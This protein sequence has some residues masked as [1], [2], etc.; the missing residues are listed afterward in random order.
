MAL[1]FPFRGFRYNK[2]AVGDFQSVVTQP[3]DKTTAS[4]QDAYYQRSSYNVV[5]I[6]LNTEKRNDP[7]T[8]YPE[9]GSTLRQ[10]I[11]Q[12]VLIQDN[13]PAIYAYYQ[14]YAFEGQT[15]L[16]KGFIALLDLKHS[17]SGII[18]H[19][20]TLAAPKQDR[21]RLLRS[22]EG[23]EDL[24]YML[25][26]DDRLE[27]VRILD[28]G[29]SGR[30]P[31][32]E[33]KD[34]FG[35]V[36]RIWA[37]TSPEAITRIQE[38]LGSQ[39]LFIADGHHRFETSVN[40][41]NECEQNGWTTDGVES[42]DK[43]MVACFN[44]AEGVTILATHRLLRDLP[45]FDARAFLKSVAQNFAIE[46]C[47][48]ADDLWEKMKAGRQD[49]VFGFYPEKLGELYLLRLKQPAIEDPILLKH[50]GA[51]RTLDV[52]ILHSLILERCLGIDEG[53]LAAQAHIDYAR[54]R[55]S[56]IRMVDE[57]KY[58]AA[59]FLNPTTA[60]QMQQVASLGERMPQKSTDFYPKLLTGLIF[61]KMHI[62]KG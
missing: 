62:R 20:H 46:R 52:S 57:G 13:L 5:R 22:I 38:A 7:D 2:N 54:E 55:E 47:S 25:Y 41:M 44:S 12:K 26:T 16:Q 21:L 36:H 8:V 17:G 35:A 61:M 34:E 6:T 18:P 10:W 60:E 23:N 56:C 53:K 42:F 58:Q 59:F 29:V 30:Q 43:R 45:M 19:E 33:V 24:I 28:A 37:I 51:Y 31:E 3:Y 49:N 48:S 39:K 27:A 50:V 1:V 9:A 15:R 14:E 11:E 32:I 4:M 40:F